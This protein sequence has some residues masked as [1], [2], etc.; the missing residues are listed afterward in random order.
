MVIQIVDREVQVTQILT[1]DQGVPMVIQ[2]VDQEVQMV[3]QIVD[4]EVRD[5]MVV[6]EARVL[7]PDQE[8]RTCQMQKFKCG[9]NEWLQ[10]ES[11]NDDDLM[12][13]KLGGFLWI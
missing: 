10:L 8:L 7:Y 2:I 3:I 6:M 12:T 1:E 11:Y 9:Q 4:Q 5:P 13:Q